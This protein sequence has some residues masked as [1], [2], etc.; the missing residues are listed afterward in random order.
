MYFKETLLTDSI[1][2]TFRENTF[3]KYTSNKKSTNRTL[4]SSCMPLMNINILLFIC[5]ISDFV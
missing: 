1:K 3:T 2:N 4:N 5:T